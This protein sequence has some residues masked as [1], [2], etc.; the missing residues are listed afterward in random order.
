MTPN[1]GT[2]LAPGQEI[3]SRLQS[4][5]SGQWMSSF[6]HMSIRLGDWSLHDPH[7]LH[8]LRHLYHMQQT[9]TVSEKLVSHFWPL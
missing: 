6:L 5:R 9:L 8:H 2:K 7:H 4:S 1:N 3:A